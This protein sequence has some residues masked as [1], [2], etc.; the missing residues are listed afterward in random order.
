MYERG[1]KW[2]WVLMGKVRILWDAP[3]RISG[4]S[5]KR[6]LKLFLWRTT[7]GDQKQKNKIR[8][9]KR[10]LCG[11]NE[12]LAS[13]NKCD[14]AEMTTWASSLQPH[15][16]MIIL[17][18]IKRNM[19]WLF[20]GSSEEMP[21]G[22]AESFKKKKKRGKAREEGRQSTMVGLLAA[23]GASGGNRR[24]FFDDT[25]AGLW[26]WRFCHGVICT[27]KSAKHW[28][29]IVG[30]NVFERLWILDLGSTSSRLLFQG[31][32]TW[33]PVWSSMREVGLEWALL[34]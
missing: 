6:N 26:S 24:I 34:R 20:L 3:V 11:D 25:K 15:T 32:Q 5:Y 31:G 14:D 21:K 33:F 19:F 9:K 16:F 1:S 12:N 7:G 18:T 2:N 13:F 17:Q 28:L 4:R 8:C 23:F 22:E 10:L 29:K 27:V 30:Q